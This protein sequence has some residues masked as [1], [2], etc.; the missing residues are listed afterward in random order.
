[1]RPVPYQNTSVRLGTNA[2]QAVAE[3]FPQ[4]DV[5]IHFRIAAYIC[6]MGEIGWS[7]VFLT[8]QFG[9]RQRFAF[10]LTDAPLTPD[11]LMEPG[12]LC[13]RCKLCVRRLPRQRHQ[14]GRGGRGRDRGAEDRVGEARR[15]QVRVRL[16]DGQPRI[17]PVHG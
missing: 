12:T 1:M 3:G 10:I 11:P 17:R 13:D 15:G 7:K 8:P 2:G 4:P 9:P 5:F 16:P 14:P 6:G